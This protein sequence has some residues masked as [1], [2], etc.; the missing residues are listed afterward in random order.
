MQL[1][2]ALTSIGL[3]NLEYETKLHHPKSIKN[4]VT[5]DLSILLIYPLWALHSFDIITSML[6]YNPG[7]SQ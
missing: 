6:T 2:Y 5:K 1:L 7:I 4:N 3:I